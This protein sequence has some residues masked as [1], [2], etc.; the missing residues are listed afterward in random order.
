MQSKC[1]GGGGGGGGQ[2][3]SQKRGK[4]SKLVQNKYESRQKSS[5]QCHN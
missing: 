4:A 1:G 3:K 2:E 5:V